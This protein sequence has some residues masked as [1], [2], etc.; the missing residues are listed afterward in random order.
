MLESGYHVADA[1]QICDAQVPG[2]ALLANVVLPQAGRVAP[3]TPPSHLPTDLPN[4]VFEQFSALEMRVQMHELL[5]QPRILSTH[6][7]LLMLVLLLRG[8]RS[9]QMPLLHI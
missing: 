1:A 2:R 3:P 9:P 5:L 8:V 6:L 7:V 4:L